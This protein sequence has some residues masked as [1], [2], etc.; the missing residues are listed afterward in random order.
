MIVWKKNSI[1]LI[2]PSKFFNSQH[3]SP[4]SKVHHL[5]VKLAWW[6]QSVC[7][8]NRRVVTIAGWSP[9][10]CACSGQRLCRS[11]PATG[12]GSRVTAPSHSAS[13]CEY[14]PVWH[15]GPLAVAPSTPH[16]AF[17]GV[18]QV[19][20]GRLMCNYASVTDWPSCRIVML[21]SVHRYYFSFQVVHANIT[22]VRPSSFEPYGHIGL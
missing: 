7:G 5:L 12:R 14:R 16:R 2:Y 6:L 8:Y 11:P 1:F 4:A 17:H 10:V 22:T 13:S 18:L 9:S 20:T 15:R 21:H 3:Y 19:E